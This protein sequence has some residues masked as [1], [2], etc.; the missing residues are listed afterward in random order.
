MVADRG[1]SAG[2][3]VRRACHA[4]KSW[5]RGSR[6]AHARA[7]SRR[8]QRDVQHHPDGSP[9][10]ASVRSAG[11]TRLRAS[12]ARGVENESVAQQRVA[13]GSISPPELRTWLE[14]QKSF[15][16]AGGYSVWRARVPRGTGSERIQVGQATSGFWRALR[17]LPALGRL[18]LATEAAQ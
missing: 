18:P 5:H 2:P 11:T 1:V 4:A 12:H 16:A 9:P 7:W 6:G 17:V 13:A 15:V 3:Q 10:S 14:R 8:E